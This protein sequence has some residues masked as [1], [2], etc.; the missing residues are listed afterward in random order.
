MITWFQ[1]VASKSE[2]MEPTEATDL[3]YGGMMGRVVDH[4]AGRRSPAPGGDGA[5]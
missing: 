1:I 5:E 3:L 2:Q 4:L